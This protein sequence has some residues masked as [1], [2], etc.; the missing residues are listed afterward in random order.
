[1]TFTHFIKRPV[2]STVISILIVLLGFIGLISLPIEQYPNIA[3]PNI[4]VIASYPGADAETVKNAVV[5]RYGLYLL[6][7]FARFGHDTGDVPS[8]HQS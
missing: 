7:R 5:T 3:P 4:M 6:Y 8:G 1:M 2:L